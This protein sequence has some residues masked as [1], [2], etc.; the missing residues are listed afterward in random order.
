LTGWHQHQKLEVISVSVKAGDIVFLYQ[1]TIGCTPNSEPWYLLCPLG[2]LGDFFTH[3]YPLY[4]A[5]IGI[6]HRGYVL[7]GVH[8]TVP[9]F[10]G[11]LFAAMLGHFNVLDWVK[12]FFEVE[13]DG[14]G[15]W[16]DGRGMGLGVS[17]G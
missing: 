16:T 3:K 5:Y 17:I 1:G 4:S 13:V 12:P 14:F 2:I 6:S 7:V 8:P 15:G 10:S 11:Q 9:W